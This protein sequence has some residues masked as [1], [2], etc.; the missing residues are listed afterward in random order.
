VEPRIPPNPLPPVVHLIVITGGGSF[1][2]S[3]GQSVTSSFSLDRDN[4]TSAVSLGAGP[5]PAGVTAVFTPSS[6]PASSAAQAFSLTL[7]AAADAAPANTTIEITAT[8]STPTEAVH[9]S[10]SVAVL[11]DSVGQVRPLYHLLTVLYAPPGTV[12][13]LDSLAVYETESS[14]GVTDLVTSSFKSGVNV[15]ASVGA[16]VDVE[17][18]TVA[19][20]GSGEF[21]AAWTSTESSSVTIEKSGSYTIKVPGPAE[22]AI[23][24][25]QDLYYL[26]LNPLINVTVD[27]Q[28]NVLWEIA[29]DGPTMLI[30]YV[31][32][33]ELQNPSLMSAGL[34]EALSARGLTTADYAQI[35]ACNPFFAGN[36]A[37]PPGRFLPTGL[38]FPYIPPQ[39]GEG[40]PSLTQTVTTTETTTTTAQTQ[41]QYTVSVSAS[42]G[43][44]VILNDTLKVGG[45]L[46]WTN[47]SKTTA[48]QG[49]TQSATVTVGCPGAGYTGPTN[50]LAFWDTVFNS[51]MFEFAA[52]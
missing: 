11:V 9:A 26:W 18:L 31:T 44:Q 49:S 50:V 36:A 52:A 15:T 51:F 25:T 24:H 22:N 8:G 28:N 19:L 40:L 29:V 2:L 17:S 32:A 37:I 10:H 27:W 7:T 5:L 12:G 33:A 43:F 16:S 13:G 21:N 42:A 1:A 34:S 4:V 23:D 48:T 45:S 35:L 39:P 14:T 6:L 38:S 46:Q 3:S 47:Q 20:G 41:V 30:Q